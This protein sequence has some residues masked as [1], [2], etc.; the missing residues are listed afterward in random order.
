MTNNL[1][2]SS[3]SDDCIPLLETHGVQTDMDFEEQHRLLEE[4]D[5][6]EEDQ[7]DNVEEVEEEGV[8]EEFLHANSYQNGFSTLFDRL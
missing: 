7:D 5:D 3:S 2:R 4:R 8:V 1:S 6:E